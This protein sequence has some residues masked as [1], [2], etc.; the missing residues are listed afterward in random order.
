M[1]PREKCFFVLCSPIPGQR[2]S[3]SENVTMWDLNIGVEINIYGKIFQLVD[4]DEYTRKFLSYQG[5]TI[6]APIPVPQR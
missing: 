4:C 2:V 3:A 1:I 5:V 6:P